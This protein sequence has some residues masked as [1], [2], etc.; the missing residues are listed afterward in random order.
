VAL[1]EKVR[2]H[3]PRL[4]IVARAR[5]VGHWQRLRSLG[6]EI[7][8][9][10]TFESAIAVG[11]RALEELGVR[12]FEAKERA[13]VFRRHNIQA[14]EAI[15]PHWQDMTTRTQMAISSRDQLERQMENDRRALERPNVRGWHSEPPGRANDD[16]QQAT[17][18]EP[19]GEIEAERGH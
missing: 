3:F 18:L 7:V 6:I 4:K 1:C 8:E 12:P 11:R 2:E 13:D 9:R 19:R 10:E 15:L 5:N 17:E 16:G 14:M